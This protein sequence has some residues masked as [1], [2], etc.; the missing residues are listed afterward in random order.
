MTMKATIFTAS[1]ASTCTRTSRV[2]IRAGLN[3]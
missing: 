3:R 1:L 2:K